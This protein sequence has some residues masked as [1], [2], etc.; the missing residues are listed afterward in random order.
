MTRANWQKALAVLVV[1][2]LAWLALTAFDVSGDLAVDDD[3]TCGGSI[4]VTGNVNVTGS[5]SMSDY[6][7]PTITQ[8]YVI[9]WQ[10]NVGQGKAF[11]DTIVHVEDYPLWVLPNDGVVRDVV[12]YLH[13]TGAGWDSLT[14]DAALDDTT[15]FEDTGHRPR[16]LATAANGSNTKAGGTGV[17]AA[18]VATAMGT[19]VAGELITMSAQ[20][21]GSPSTDARGLVVWIVFEPDY[22]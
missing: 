12:C 7:C 17:R 2:A 13:L 15:V 5:A 21:H 22:P 4:T 18:N 19:G 11:G 16:F 3:I 10:E 6:S 8:R 9:P 20:V 1:A 14:I